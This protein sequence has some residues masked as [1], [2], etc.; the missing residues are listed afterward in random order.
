MIWDISEDLKIE[1][2]DVTM[3]MEGNAH[4]MCWSMVWKL[5]MVATAMAMPGQAAESP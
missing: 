4:R 2:D 3:R 1:I 5:R